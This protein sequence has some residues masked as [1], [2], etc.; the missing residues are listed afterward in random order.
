MCTALSIFEAIR[1]HLL[2]PDMITDEQYIC[3]QLTKHGHRCGTASQRAPLRGRGVADDKSAL[4]AS[5]YG[6]IYIWSLPKG[7]QFQNN[8]AQCKPPGPN[9]WLTN[10]WFRWRDFFLEKRDSWIQRRGKRSSVSE[11]VCF[12]F[13]SEV[14]QLMRGWGKVVAYNQ[15][16]L[17]E[18][19]WHRSI[20]PPHCLVG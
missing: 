6:Q 5:K 4:W 9:K 7:C 19:I 18:L 16:H 3:F 14:L 13:H 15:W 17:L 12:V 2:S 10:K 8:T 11:L 20:R 1:P